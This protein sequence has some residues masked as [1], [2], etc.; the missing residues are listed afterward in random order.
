LPEIC[1]YDDIWIRKDLALEI[2]Y[3]Y[4]Y[5]ED[6]LSIFGDMRRNL[7]E[8]FNILEERYA[9]KEVD[10][11]YMLKRH[12]N[13]ID[14][15]YENA[16]THLKEKCKV[17]HVLVARHLER[18]GDILGKIGSSLVFIESGKRIWIK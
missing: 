4:C 7:I 18:M 17:E 1:W 14:E 6:L 16:I 3:Y 13:L 15:C 10:I 12:D 11:V 8:M 5:D 9:G 2:G